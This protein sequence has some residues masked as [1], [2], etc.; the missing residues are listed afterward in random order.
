MRLKV[1]DNTLKKYLAKLP[2]KKYS[3]ISHNRQLSAKCRVE[4]HAY[5]SWR[6]TF[7]LEHANQYVHNPSLTQNQTHC[8]LSYLFRH[9]VYVKLVFAVK[10]GKCE[11]TA[12]RDLQ[13]RE[14]INVLLDITR[15]NILP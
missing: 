8:I 10:S 7:V 2:V 13:R 11:H 9:I 1:T 12:I 5:E 15:Q 6:H 14:E 3:H 4:L